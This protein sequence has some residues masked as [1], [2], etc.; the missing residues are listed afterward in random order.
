[1]N[2]FGCKFCDEATKLTSKLGKRNCRRKN[3]DSL[4]WA[5]IT[6]F[7]VNESRWCVDQLIFLRPSIYSSIHLF[8]HPSVHPSIC[9]SIHLFIHPSVHPSICSSIHLFIHPSVH[10]SICSSINLIIHPSVHPSICSSIHLFIHQSNHPSICSSIHLFIHPFIQTNPPDQSFIHRYI[11]PSIQPSPYPSLTPD[12]DPRRLA[13]STVRWYGEYIEV[14]L[15]V[16]HH[17]HDLR[18]LCTL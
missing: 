6:V 13:W 4:L 3:F 1:M 16:L 10:P 14:G 12:P 15:I 8:I 9:S 18:K 2:L 5:I 11:H 7:Q 17:P